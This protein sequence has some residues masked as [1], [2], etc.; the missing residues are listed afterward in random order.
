MLSL[1]HIFDK[2]LACCTFPGDPYLIS[3]R[4][5]YCYREQTWLKVVSRIG[6]TTVFAF[7]HKGDF[8]VFPEYLNLQHITF[9]KGQ[10]TLAIR[11]PLLKIHCYLCSIWILTNH[12]AALRRGARREHYS[13]GNQE[14]QKDEYYS[15]LF[16][17]KHAKTSFTNFTGSLIHGL[18]PECSNHTIFFFGASRTCMYSSA[19]TVGALTS[20]RPR[21]K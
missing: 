14:R 12:N 18:W 6:F 9:L 21:K 1:T 8:S 13:N 19:S 7:D 16:S 3:I 5:R 4:F 11:A 17:K 2:N 10:F 20:C 15:V